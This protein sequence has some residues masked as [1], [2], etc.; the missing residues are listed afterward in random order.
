MPSSGVVTFLFTDIEGSTQL[1]E[2]RPERMQIAVARHDAIL[3]S[4]VEQHGGR[5]VKMAGD[6][7]HAVFDD[8][9][10]AVTASL[11]LQRAL[12]NP[13][14][15][16]GIE[17]RVRCG[18]HAGVDERRDD[19]FFG[20]AVNRA[21]RIS[22]A[23][24]GGQILL[25]QAVAA[26]VRERLPAGAM[27]RELGSVRLRGLATPEQVY[28]L[29]YPGLRTD[30][31]ALRSLEATPNN[32][33]LQLTS[34]VGREDEVT[35]VRKLLESTRLLTLVGVGGIGKTRLSLQAAARVMDDYPDGVWF[36]ELAAVVDAQLVPQSVASVLAVKEEAGHPV[37][38]ALEKHVKNRQLLLI[39]DNCEH[40][41][42][43]CAEFSKRLLQSGS[44]TKILASSREPLHVAGETTY[45]VLGLA[46]PDPDQPITP[47]ALTQY[48][49]VRLFVDRTAAVQPAFQVTDQNAT[50]IREICRRLDGIPLAIELAAARVRALS[51]AEIA[52]RLGDRFRLLTSGDRTALPRQQTLRALIDWSY[53]LLTE[54]ERSLFRRLAVFAGGWTHE[55]A[56]AVCVGGF[57]KEDTV[58]DLVTGLVDKSLVV[59]ETGE[60]YRLL[61]TVRQ[62]A[63]ERLTEIGEAAK[64]RNRHLAF[65]VKL[66][67]R[68]R[69]ELVGSDQGAWLARLDLE[70]EN[71]FSAHAWCDHAQEGAAL[72]LRLVH[73]TLL[74]WVN[75]GLLSLGL[76]MTIDALAREGA[77]GR[78][79][80]RCRGLFNAGQLCCWMGRYEEARGY[81]EESLAIARELGDKGRIAMAL[82][83][84]GAACLG[85]GD[86]K[87]ARTHLQE[88]LTL[89]QEQGNK[90]ELAGAL[91][92][93]AQLHRVEAELDAAEPLYEQLLKLARELDD[94]ESIAIGLLNLAMVSIGR[95]SAARARAMLLEVLVIAG[96]TGSKPV[97]QS[98]VEVSAGLA[99]LRGEWS[100]AARFYGAAESQAAQTGLRRDPADDAFLAQHIDKARDALGEPAFAAAE[101]AGR[102]LANEAV[103]TEARAWLEGLPPD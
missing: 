14:A 101:S 22:G 55:A 97:E 27:L 99:S 32:L 31:P 26:L 38:K 88:A 25:S 24:H 43:A 5:V 37:I 86:R 74:Y 39:L 1:W 93:L 16:G 3:R 67:E 73:S 30:F 66:A 8:P 68:A 89:A 52:T 23:A 46:I 76:R 7:V 94:R 58:L 72:G 85:Q 60:R 11:E 33:P 62:Y 56:E 6:G 49:S 20:R 77:Q 102:A 96:E 35:E 51:V 80:E 29:V 79:T 65:Y 90:R 12:G 83:P 42:H 41:I 84:L 59:S 17:L 57:V 18:L 87:T 91:N 10:D 100:R 71:L 47:A 28:Q 4:A 82:Q 70:R 21:A 61:D 50:A 69:R 63:Q 81:L 54:Q 13:D 34:F 98:V 45:S 15:T 48:E 92:A 44:R 78:T 53:D 36:I 95:R 40:L 103:M 75:R 9:L 19:D 64:V 2:E